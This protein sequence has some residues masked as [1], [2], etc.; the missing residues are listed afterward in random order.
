MYLRVD[1]EP[2]LVVES[3]D[4]RHRIIDRVHDASHLRINRT[5][6]MV[7]AKYY[8]PGLTNDVKQYVRSFNN[9]YYI[10]KF[11]RGVPKIY[12]TGIVAKT[13]QL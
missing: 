13:S 9:N 10:A 5:L 1:K 4:H 2:R 3:V 6:S 7:N 11:Y 12:D 8:W